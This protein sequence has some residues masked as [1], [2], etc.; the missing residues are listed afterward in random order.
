M[1]IA[2]TDDHRQIADAVAAWAA[3]STPWA[4]ARAQESAPDAWRKHWAEIAELGIL[5]A[6]VPE[7]HGGAGGSVADLAVLLEAAATALVPGPLLPSTLAALL[8]AD[9]GDD[10]RPDDR[11]DLAGALGDLVRGE[12]T[13]GVALGAGRLT[14]RANGDGTVTVNGTSAPVIGGDQDAV[15]LLAARGDGADVWF[16]ATSDAAGVELID[17]TDGDFSRATAQAQLTGVTARPLPG[18]ETG[19]VVDLAA[20]LVA[21]EASGVAAWCLR[22]ATEYA[23]VREQFGQPIGSF[24]AV[25][26]LCAEMLC[27]AELAAAVAWDAALVGEPGAT[28]TG[29]APLA[30]A[31]AAAVAVDAAV[32]T[33]QDCIQVLGGIGFTWEHDAHLYLRRALALRGVLGGTARWRRRVGELTLHGVR[34]R[35][36]VDVGD[37]EGTRAEIRRAVTDIAGMPESHRRVALADAGLLCPHWPRP[38][39]RDASAAEQLV[40]DEELHRAGVLRPDLVIGAW[41]APTILRHGTAEQ[42]ERFVRPTLTGELVWCQLFSEPGAGSDLASLRTRAVREPGGWRLNGQKVWTSVA[43]RAHWGICLART[44]P[45][46]AK[47]AGLTYFLLDMTAPG[48]DIRPLRELTGEALFNEVFL[49]DVF[50]ADEF[51]VGGPGDGWR[52]ARATLGNERV[53][54]GSSADLGESVERLVELVGLLG[55]GA[56]ATPAIETLGELVAQA[57]ACAVLDARAVVRRLDGLDPGAESSVRKLVGVRNRQA[58]ADAALEL[59]SEVQAAAPQAATA[60]LES[61]LWHAALQTRC[62]SIAGGTTQV[63]LS[64][65]AERILGLPRG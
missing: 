56:A 21:A 43:Q 63:L 22:T 34:R 40:I 53:A 29:D 24:Q 55:D 2:V 6:A 8:L 37:A 23:K 28:C 62:L 4:T 48:I 61:A 41:A 18:I 38:Y 52:L 25:K 17:R 27:R 49:D 26:H 50:V 15:L 35:L 32:R 7:S 47:H 3:R 42:I 36:H 12:R 46:A 19:R 51:V 10:Q 58:V 5:G 16:L 57:L 20:V 1:P 39:G 44:D 31:V 9:T 13:C 54:M 59:I 60:E 45:D 33:A 65:A 11:T 64:L 30:A 14:A